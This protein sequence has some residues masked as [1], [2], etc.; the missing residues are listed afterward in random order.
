MH[1]TAAYLSL[2]A[3]Q[4]SKTNPRK[5][6]DEAKL[7]E[8]ADSIKT[9]GVVQA[10]LV[11][12]SRTP[13]NTYELVAGERR[14]RASRLAGL[15]EIPA[16]IR[17]LTDTE[18]L[19][20][21]VIENLQRNDLS[22]LEEA[23]GY[24]RLMGCAHE[25]GER[26]TA[27][28]I[29]AKVGKSKGYVYA[30]LKLLSLC[31]EGRVALREGKMPASTAL[32]VAR[33]PVP[34]LQAKA[35]KEIL[36]PDYED[37]P[38]SFRDAKHHVE[39]HY[40]LRLKEAPFKPGDAKLLPEVGACTTCPNRTGNQPELFA[41][42]ASADVCTD[43]ACFDKKKKAFAERRR[44]EAIAGG[45]TVITGKEA[46]KIMPNDY[47]QPR[48]YVR[49]DAACYEDPK[50]RNYRQLLGKAAAEAV[51]LEKPGA[52]GEFV[53]VLPEDQVAQALK[54]KGYDFTTKADE[55]RENAKAEFERQVEQLSRVRTYLALREQ[56]AK[57]GLGPED[58]RAMIVKALGYEQLSDELLALW[59]AKPSEDSDA[60]LEQL[61]K[62]APN[63]QL[64]PM[65]LDA[66]FPEPTYY[67]N[68]WED[69]AKLRGIDVKAIQREVKAEL[70][71]KAKEAAQDAPA[72]A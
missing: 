31:E 57:K 3:I 14:W 54:E 55:K 29:A 39:E 49:L 28:E 67:D 35:V 1:A 2:D 23:E 40:M 42:I 5:A 43:P 64:V 4:P 11:R 62:K 70:K 9:H 10:I 24:E 25:N 32:L 30:R 22:E 44:E 17:Q 16:T 72:E 53:E 33:I 63:E 51:L 27:E 34:K 47:S 20:I 46:K 66:I 50:R 41:D 19:E 61:V 37:E 18:V 36:E 38:M 60:D 6:F 52:P 56:I 8:L 15:A 21:Q 48:G 26:Y 45:R 69:L 71:A 58:L 7:Q 68:G 12:P 59:G 65:L 13:D